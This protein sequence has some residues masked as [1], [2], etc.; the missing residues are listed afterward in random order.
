MPRLIIHGCKLSE[1]QLT[2]LSFSFTDTAF[3]ISFFS[4]PISVSARERR[5]ISGQYRSR[6]RFTHVYRDE[7]F[8]RDII[9]RVR[10]FYNQKLDSCSPLMEIILSGRGKILYRI[11]EIMQS[12]QE[13]KVL[14]E[15]GKYINI[16]K[17]VAN[18][19][20]LS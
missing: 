7:I 14:G 6:Y 13:K 4:L 2:G 15:S 12:R 1:P 20:C 11:W 18:M 10:I 5:D 8:P 9:D 17:S 16:L 3:D 19:R